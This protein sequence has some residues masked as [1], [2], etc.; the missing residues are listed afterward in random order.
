MEKINIHF[1]GDLFVSII[2]EGEKENNIFTDCEDK[3]KY[4]ILMKTLYI[5]YKVKVISYTVMNNYIHLI[6]HAQDSIYISNFMKEVNTKYAIYFNKKY[7]I[8]NKMFK[9]R[10]KAKPIFTNDRLLKLIKYIHMNP[11]KYNLVKKENQYKYSSF[12]DYNNMTNFID[13]K[14]YNLIFKEKLN[15]KEKYKKFLDLKY[16]ELYQEKNQ[17]NIKLIIEEYLEKRKIHIETLKKEKI[18]LKKFMSYIILNSYEYNKEKLCKELKLEN[19][20]FEN[21]TNFKII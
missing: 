6:I 2:I 4:I 15:K 11:V 1:I 19:K 5:K 21:K 9:G 17:D 13:D 7:I 18:E 16:Y 12:N 8:E 14:T 20:Y 10:L 3:E